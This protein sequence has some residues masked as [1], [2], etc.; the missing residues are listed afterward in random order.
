MHLSRIHQAPPS[1]PHNDFPQLNT[2]HLLLISTAFFSC[3]KAHTSHSV[4]VWS[5]CWTTAY[6]P[7]QFASSFSWWFLQ[8]SPF[9]RYCSC[10]SRLKVMYSPGYPL[11]PTATVCA[12]LWSLVHL[13][14]LLFNLVKPQRLSYSSPFSKTRQFLWLT[15]LRVFNFSDSQSLFKIWTVNHIHLYIYCMLYLNVPFLH[16]FKKS[17]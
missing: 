2:N 16:T 3:I 11:T 1:L 13:L 6:L 5:H 12:S 9:A 4:S 7:G 17:T 10:M 8:C 14:Y 15:C